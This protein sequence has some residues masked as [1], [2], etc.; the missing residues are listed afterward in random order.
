[1]QRM[2]NC[3]I[4]SENQKAACLVAGLSSFLWALHAHSKG[5]LLVFSHDLRGTH[6]SIKAG[7]DVAQVRGQQW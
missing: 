2:F 5:G 7:G 3:F 6:S 1:M 4:I